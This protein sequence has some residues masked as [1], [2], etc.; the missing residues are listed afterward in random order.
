M[1]SNKIKHQEKKKNSSCLP[2]L[3]KSSPFNALLHEHLFRL[4]PFFRFFGDKCCCLKYCVRKGH[5]VDAQPPCK[6]VVL[7]NSA[8]QEIT[9]S[10]E[11]MSECASLDAN[12][13]RIVVFLVGWN[14]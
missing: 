11:N 8:V 12:S 10:P 6:L 9:L 3:K 7:E 13:S 4:F 14:T 5:K 2:P 1:Y